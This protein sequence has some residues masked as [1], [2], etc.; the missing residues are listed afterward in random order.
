MS[1]PSLLT[2]HNNPKQVTVNAQQ[3]RIKKEHFREPE[4]T[5][6]ISEKGQLRGAT[7]IV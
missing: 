2:D 4:S 7:Q 5:R 1:N 3:M 6:E